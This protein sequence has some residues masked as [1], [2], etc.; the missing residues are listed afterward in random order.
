MDGIKDPSSFK[1]TC[2]VA[3]LITETLAFDATTV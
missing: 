2:L 1:I 3:V